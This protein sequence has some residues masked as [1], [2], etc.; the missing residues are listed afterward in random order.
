MVL[1]QKLYE[2]IRWLIAIVMPA[3]NILFATLAKAWAWDIPVEAI[4]VTLDAVALFLGTIFGISKLSNDK[5]EAQKGVK[6]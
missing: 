1:P 5:S 4:L 2:A 3:F 6:K